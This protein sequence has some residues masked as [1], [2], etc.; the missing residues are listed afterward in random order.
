MIIFDGLYILLRWCLGGI[1]IF[2]GITK[3]MAPETFAIL[4]DAYGLVPGFLLLPVSLILPVLEIT[5]GA[6]LLFDVKG[7]LSLT[8]GLM[9]LFIAVM[10]YG[11]WMGLDIDC[12]CF[13]PGD[14][15]SEAF[16]GLKAALCRDV[17]LL[18]GIVLLFGWRRCRG[19]VPVELALSSNR[20]RREG[21]TENDY[22]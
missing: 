17:F 15:E 7:S 13:G 1:F 18:T 20:L 5:A 22:V 16:H 8:A 4:I 2:A 14:P 6:G 19:I 12:G 3:L 10:G 9:V 21:G 11:I